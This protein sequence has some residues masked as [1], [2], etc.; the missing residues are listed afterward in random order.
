M[1]PSA[2]P[3]VKPGAGALFIHFG[4]E[5]VT[6]ALDGHLAEFPQAVGFLTVMGD[7]AIENRPLM[8]HVF[9]YLAEH[10]LSWLDATGS[11][12]SQ[13]HA[14]GGEKN[15]IAYTLQPVSLSSLDEPGLYIARL[16][17]RARKSGT[18]LA[19]L[20]YH[21]KGFTRFA[22]AL[23]LN[24]DRLEDA[25]IAPVKSSDLEIPPEGG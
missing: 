7:R 10:S 23:S 13:S 1:E 11:P 6:E 21:A 19:L 25:G 5:E 17:A 3:Y 2:Y 18:A 4:A 9:N 16:A 12:R 15:V 8:E 14:L 24:E 20:S 22:E